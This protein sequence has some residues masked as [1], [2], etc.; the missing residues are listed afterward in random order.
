[1]ELTP[2][3]FNTGTWDRLRADMEA[4]LLSMRKRNDADLDAVETAAIRGQIRELNYWLSLA[5]P[6]PPR[7][8]PAGIDL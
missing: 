5:A 1:M 3:D 2:G 7:E 8:E 6:Q 4:R